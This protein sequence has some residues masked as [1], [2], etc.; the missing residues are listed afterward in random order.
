MA[1]TDPD[2][3]PH[4]FRRW[5]IGNVPMWLDWANPAMINLDN[6]TWN[7]EYDVVVENTGI[8]AVQWVYFL[9]LGLCS[10]APG[11][12]LFPSSGGRTRVG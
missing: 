3:R 1:L 4:G 2:D 7:E 12:L 11:A 10:P 8:V 9:I 6:R 5:E